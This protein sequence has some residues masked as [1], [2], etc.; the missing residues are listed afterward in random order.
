MTNPRIDRQF[1]ALLLLSLLIF[2]IASF[3][4]Y[5]KSVHPDGT[6]SWVDF[7][8]YY[9]A[10]VN[11][12]GGG[13]IYTSDNGEFIYKYS[14]L[15]ALMMSVIRFY[16]ATLADALCVWYAILFISFAVSLYLLK[17]ILF[18]PEAARKMK[19]L[20]AIAFLYIFRYAILNNFLKSY[21]P[22]LWPAPVRIFDMILWILPAVF[23]PALLF[24]NKER[25]E[26]KYLLAISLAV[27]FIFRFL[28]L[29]V[30]RGQVSLIILLLL[31][32]FSSNIIRKKDIAAGIY[33]GLAMIIKL[34]PAIFLAYLILKKRFKA[35]LSAL[36][37]FA[38]FLFI[39]SFKTGFDSNI[40]LIKQWAGVLT[41]TIPQEYIQYKNQSL[42]AAISRFLSRNSDIAFIGLS[43]T[44]LAVL[45]GFLYIL[46]ISFLAWCINKKR[47]IANTAE[48]TAADLSIF[49]AAMTLLTP[50]GT[51]TAFVYLLLPVTFLIKEAFERKLKDWA[52]N[53]GLITSSAIFYI[54][55]P[56]IIGDL[57][58]IL[59][60]YSVM[61][62]AVLI[63]LA[64]L[65][66]VRLKPGR[67]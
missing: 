54:N 16:T 4:Y 66:Y 64:V 14:P 5:H 19:F 21:L 43:E 30:D 23:I 42:M 1:L 35:L 20:N 11:I 9:Y 49:F 37:A 7:R 28:M 47:E 12:E 44:S 40:G 60:K 63:I 56:D 55:S 53:A 36:A 29:N 25:E 39:P 59:H 15:F 17:E 52:I 62:L 24:A 34:V 6:I 65:A 46:F 2:S 32:L 51:K 22:P 33:L 31:M 45:T 38:I 57:N 8:V 10:G 58:V 27:L 18:Y 61:T 3:Y 50:V 26:R 48:D 67:A 13:D 41:M